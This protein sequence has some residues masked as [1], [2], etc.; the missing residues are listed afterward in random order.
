[1]ES[2]ETANAIN[3]E[4]CLQ[5]DC[6]MYCEDGMH[7]VIGTMPCYR[8][9]VTVTVVKVTYSGLFDTD[10]RAERCGGMTDRLFYCS[11]SMQIVHICLYHDVYRD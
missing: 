4:L 8:H 10:C 2:G 6:V 5:I 11:V 9:D 3:R 7:S 1:M